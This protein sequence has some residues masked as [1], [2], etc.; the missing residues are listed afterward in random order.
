MTYSTSEIFDS[1]T[2]I[3]LE[4]GLITKQAEDKSD[5]K[6]D[7]K[8]LST[9]EALYGVRAPGESD[10]NIIE[11]A[12]PDPIIIAPAYDKI[13][14]LVENVKERHDIM[15]WIATKPTNG[16]LTQ[17]AYVAAHKN[18]LDELIKVG[19][20]LDRNNKNELMSLADSCSERLTKTAF[21]PPLLLAGL[22]ASGI[23]VLYTAIS[24]NMHL[25]QGVV[26]DSEKAL[27]ELQEVFST[28][29][30]HPE[31]K[32]ELANL[33]NKIELLKEAGKK[34]S[35]IELHPVT[36]SQTNNAVAGFIAL[37]EKK[38]HAALDLISG[39]SIGCSEMAKLL[40]EYIPVLKLK[41]QQF[42]GAHTDWWEPIRRTYRTVIPSDIEDAIGA[43][44]ALKQSCSTTPSQ[45]D[46]MSKLFKELRTKTQETV[47]EFKQ[48]LRMQSTNPEE[49]KE[50]SEELTKS[51]EQ[52]REKLEE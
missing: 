21:F 43:L 36:Q 16:Y 42:E 20:L 26:Q 10:K 12:H 25:S 35:M 32:T 23:G 46:A 44:E 39:F 22:V 51:K 18:L 17:K 7:K 28:Y 6:T 50:K 45:M 11:Q 47:K 41:S 2:K 9:I 52:S 3:A 34:I 29:S 38:D 1:Y 40:N 27:T 31:L 48:K 33:I 14:G 19:F 49:L 4:Q 30:D 8:E 24:Q 15:C 37:Q 13:N 5:S